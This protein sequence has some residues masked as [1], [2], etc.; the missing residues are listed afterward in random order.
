MKINFSV[1]VIILSLM[2][3]LVAFSPKPEIKKESRSPGMTNQAHHIKIITK[4]ISAKEVLV[5]KIQRPLNYMNFRCYSKTFKNSYLT[6]S[7]IQKYNLTVEQ[8][9]SSLSINQ[10]HGEVI[11]QIQKVIWPVVLLE[12]QSQYRIKF[13]ENKTPRS[14]NCIQLSWNTESHYRLYINNLIIIQ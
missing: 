11:Q 8:C 12:F 9:F 13:N 6:N 2:I 3:I 7:K 4:L 5:P 10:M 1:K 14:W